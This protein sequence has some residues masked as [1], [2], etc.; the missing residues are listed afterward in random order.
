V[1]PEG[2]KGKRR[3]AGS[4]YGPSNN[5]MS[6][7]D[8][9]PHL[10]PREKMNREHPCAEP[11]AESMGEIDQTP[12]EE[13]TDPVPNIQRRKAAREATTQ[14]SRRSDGKTT[15]AGRT[16]E[17]SAAR[18]VGECLGVKPIWPSATSSATPTTA[19]SRPAGALHDLLKV[20]RASGGSH[21]GSQAA[22]KVEPAATRGTASTGRTISASATTST[23][24]RPAG[25]LHDPLK[26]DRASERL[27]GARG[28]GR[29]FLSR[30][31]RSYISSGSE[32]RTP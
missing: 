13:L 8:I 20:D 15:R 4:V 5:A 28:S 31:V 3:A 2:D 6:V 30:N 22:L 26:V 23:S 27:S 18:V 10:L 11:E 16:G 21:D 24:T 12:K 17:Q 29:R 14:R 7:N 9:L 1:A 19:S 25:A 32:L